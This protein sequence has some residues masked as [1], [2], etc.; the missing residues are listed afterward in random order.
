MALVVDATHC[1]GAYYC[2]VRTRFKRRRKKRSERKGQCSALLPV[3]HVPF[4]AVNN[5]A[6]GCKIHRLIHSGMYTHP[7][8]P[9]SLWI[10][11]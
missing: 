8:L 9:S 1:M 6:T 7:A 11:E 5:P 4:R 3:H 2:L 10:L